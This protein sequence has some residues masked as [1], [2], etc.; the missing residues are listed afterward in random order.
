MLCD[1]KA[2]GCVTLSCEPRTFPRR[3]ITEPDARSNCYALRV[4]TYLKGA[5]V[6]AQPQSVS[7]VPV[8][9]GVTHHP[10]VFKI[11]EVRVLLKQEFKGMKSL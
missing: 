8:A 9:Q 5:G 1:T 4:L 7:V 10:Y 6:E 2:D 11:R 3:G